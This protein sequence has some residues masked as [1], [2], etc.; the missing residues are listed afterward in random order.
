MTP[1]EELRRVLALVKSA[2]S[3]NLDWVSVSA[4]V[5]L[6]KVQ[7]FLGDDVTEP[8]D[9]ALEDIDVRHLLDWYYFAGPT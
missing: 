3:G 6:N 5:P 1:R 2:P 9:D 7:A 4:G 8:R